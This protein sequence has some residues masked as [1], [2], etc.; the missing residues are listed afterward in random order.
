MTH[1]FDSGGFFTVLI[2]LAHSEAAA[3]HG[4]LAPSVIEGEVEEKAIFSRSA[5]PAI[6][7]S[8]FLLPL[9]YKIGR[10]K[11]K[12]IMSTTSVALL[13]KAN[14]GQACPL[15]SSLVVAA[16]PQSIQTLQLSP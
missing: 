2:A 8:C 10:R 3:A 13:V 1:T 7:T 9:Y 14:M 16:K 5:A 15:S 11:L 4:A 12:R 6:T